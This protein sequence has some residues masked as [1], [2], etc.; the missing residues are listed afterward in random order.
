MLHIVMD[1]AGDAP[2]SW[3]SEFNINVIPVN[4]QFGEKTYLQGIDIKDEDYYKLADESKTVPKTSQPTPAQFVQFYERIA[5]PGESILSIHVTGKLSGT[6]ESAQL[7]ARE[8]VNKLNIFPFDSASGSAA[9][10]FMCREAR[11]LDR[12]GTTIDGILDR[13]EY[14]RKTIKIVLALDT[15]EYVKRSGRVQTLQAALA[16]I[17][18][19]KPIIDL[20]DGVLDMRDRVRTRSRSLEYLINYMEEKLGGSS[21]NVAVVHSQDIKSGESLL[22]KV[23]NR[24]TCN[25]LILTNLSIGIAANLGPGTIGI[26]AYPVSEGRE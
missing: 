26:V 24:L 17:L 14:M 5:K 15:L 20:Q 7:A 8:L 19:V 4:I 2:S 21:A 6:F 10:G 22:S 23:R 1:S 13:L 11:L 16:S 18:N 12:A 3:I 9:M 25:C